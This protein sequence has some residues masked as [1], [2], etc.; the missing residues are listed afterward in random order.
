MP[1]GTV[2]LVKGFLGACNDFLQISYI[3]LTQKKNNPKQYF[4][5]I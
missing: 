1:L 3:Y 2:V 4:P 5:F